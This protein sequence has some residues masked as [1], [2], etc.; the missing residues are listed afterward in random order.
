MIG[1]LLLVALY[2]LLNIAEDTRVEMKMVNK[3]IVPMLIS[4]LDR[5]NIELLILVVSFLK[6]LSIFVENKDAMA[7][8]GVVEKMARI[9]PCEHDV[10]LHVSVRFLLNLSFDPLLRE[11]L[12]KAGL[13][14]KLV[15]LLTNEQVLVFVL[16]LLYH[17]S[18][19]DRCKSMF[20]YTDCIPLV[21]VSPIQTV[22]GFIL[23]ISGKC[24][25]SQKS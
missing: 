12:V 2:L 1:F 15:S 17:I 6:K 24:R 11:R 7:R 4:L 14:P 19:D 25:H 13:L 18:M 20:S 23:S 8:L 22:P 21:C 5:D 16:C 3:E 9:V 10:L